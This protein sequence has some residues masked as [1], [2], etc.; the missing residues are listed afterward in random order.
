[1]K[2]FLSFLLLLSIIFSFASCKRDEPPRER[3]LID[4]SSYSVVIP[5]NADTLTKYASENFV[6]LVK[7]KLDIELT[8]VNDT[9][10]EVECEILIGET[11][12]QSSISPLELQNGQ[13]LLFKSEKK[14]VMQGYGIYVGAA[15]GDF[16]NKFT[17]VSD[18]KLDITDVPS[19][20]TPLN[21]AFN[22]EYKSVIFM[23]GDG[24]G[25]NHIKMAEYSDMKFYARDF[26][27]V[28]VSVTRSKSVLNGDATY[29]D[30]AASGTAMST[31]YKTINNYVGMGP[32]TQPIKNVRELAYENGAK[33][34]VI[35]TDV[36]TG[37]TPSSYIC[38]NVSRENTDELQAEI[39]RVVSE[40]KIDYIAGDVADELTNHVKNALNE[41]S[42]DN[43]QF[44]IMIEEGMI[45]KA[46]H[47]KNTILATQYVKR[48]NDAIAYATQFVMCHP[49][50]AL[51]VTADHETG[52]LAQSQKRPS[53]FFFQSYE[54]TNLDVPLFAL[55]AGTE[56]FNGV[57]TENIDL[58]KFTARAYSS[59]PFGQSESVE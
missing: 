32:D 3:E 4:L 30:S 53:Y 35:T 42:K 39:D 29:T 47:S 56:I 52:N 38:H 57:K 16:I 34:A 7:D 59:E 25:E 48:Y 46:S 6:S 43:S 55:G 23:I 49:D 19:E 14:I 58:A 45:D 17:S 20:A 24:M 44:F 22:T 9:S 12:R 8:V 11:N 40:G 54:H 33:T 27:S 28:G 21:F 10:A 15:C 37:A 31:G 18:G 1:M 2:R 5:E 51:I 36:I 13:Y 26:S 50:T 41:I